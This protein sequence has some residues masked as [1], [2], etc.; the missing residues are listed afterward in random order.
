MQAKGLWRAC[1]GPFIADHLP[2][3]SKTVAPWVKLC[4]TDSFEHDSL[5]SRCMM[6]YGKNWQD[7]IYTYTA[8]HFWFLIVT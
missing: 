6:L 8:M 5:T 2:G 4:E 3:G 7:L 1:Y